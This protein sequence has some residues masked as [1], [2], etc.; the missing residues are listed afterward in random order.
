[1]LFHELEKYSLVGEDVGRV[2]LKVVEMKEIVVQ[3]ARRPGVRNNKGR[4]NV[5]HIAQGA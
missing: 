4:V 5:T 2:A 1:M 3:K